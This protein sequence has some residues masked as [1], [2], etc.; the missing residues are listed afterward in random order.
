MQKST[1]WFCFYFIVVALYAVFS[2]S[3]TDPNLVLSG[4]GPYWSFQQWM[5]QTFFTNEQLLTI[6]YI[7][8]VSLLLAGWWGVV[9][10]IRATTHRKEVLIKCVLLCLPLFFSYN[11][12]SHDVFNYIFNAK[13]VV[14]YKDNPHVHVALDY[15][16]DLWV[17]FMHN[18]HTPA[19]YGYGWTIFSLIPYILGMNKFVL[20]WLIFRALNIIAIPLLFILIC[21]LG[22][23][24]RL[25]VKAKDLAIVFMSP[26]FLIEVMS[27]SH[28]DLW[29]LLPA[30][31]A[32]WLVSFVSKRQLWKRVLI[33]LFFLL[34]SISTK[35]ATVTL[36]PLW[37]LGTW[38]LV[39]L[40][41][42]FLR[43]VP[44]SLRRW[45]DLAWAFSRA[46]LGLFASLLLF[47]P[48]LTSRSQFFHPWYLLWSL[49]W[50]PLISVNWWRNVLIALA[51][52]SLFR[53]APWLLAGGFQDTVLL[54]QQAVTWLGGL[55]ALGLLLTW[56][57]FTKKS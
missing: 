21:K 13:M 51:I 35:L 8:L 49:I 39:S 27:N 20:T 57:N 44:S 2:F 56:H 50:L 5:W 26:L 16:D 1:L 54:Q 19:P 30:V 11:A 48:L 31:A 36:I 45:L 47:I 7:L 3:M 22:E 41:T 55:T 9:Q 23:R 18:T 42:T 28:N 6:G 24:L 12:L 37:V 38:R 10:S 43:W 32:L 14:V 53:Y 33:S 40:Y 25:D 52:S 15:S 34:A 46:N 4:W 17:R 29:M